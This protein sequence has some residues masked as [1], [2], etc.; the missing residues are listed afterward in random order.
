MRPVA[1]AVLATLAL[2]CRKP[3][4]G[5][6][7]QVVGESGRIRSEDP[8][9]RSSPWFDGT[10]V[11]LVAARGETLGLQVRHSGGAVRLAIAG[12]RVEGFAVEPR[13]VARAS[14]DMYGGSHGVGT[15]PDGLVA[16]AAPATDPAYFEVTAEGAPGPYEG[17]LVV[18][19][20]HIPVALAITR[21]EL[22]PLPLSV[23]AYYDPRELVWANLGTGTLDAP[24]VEERACIAMFRAHGVLLSPDLPPSAWPARRALVTT[25]FVPA[26]IPDDPA[27]AGAAAAAWIAQTRGTG[28]VPFAIPVDEPRTPE[29]RAKVRALAAAVRGAGGGPGRF[30]YAVTGDPRAD[31]GGLVDLYVTLRAKLADGFTRWAYNGAPPHAGSMVLDA[32]SPGTRTWG[33]I[34]WRWHVPVWYVWDA[35]YWHDR[36][37]RRRKGGAADPHVPGQS[38]MPAGRALDRDDS[39]SFDDGEDRG[40]LDGVLALPG[41]AKAPCKPTLRLAALR[42]G[43]EDRALLALAARCAPDATARL[44]AGL[45]PRALGDAP[46]SG[47][48][49]WPADEAAWEAARRR[50]LDLAGA[51]A[52]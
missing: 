17:E 19:A 4:P 46:D 29:A 35:L 31:D 14:T 26:A 25:P 2:G 28:Q 30:L 5:R 48:A 44:A 40:N 50:L 33:W 24:S 42:R 36:H 43:L 49:A 13:V 3:D 16:A 34:A 11:T 15:Y 12:A 9:P 39:I 27:P 52:R 51:C 22:P 20:R 37:N 6:A 21:V 41:D 45:V 32:E 1:I 7:V 18:G 38:S 23:W 10:R 8:A 47:A